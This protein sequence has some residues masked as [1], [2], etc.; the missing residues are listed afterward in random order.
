MQQAPEM[1]GSE[2]GGLLFRCGYTGT[3]LKAGDVLRRLEAEPS[4]VAVVIGVAPTESGTR[5]AARRNVSK[6]P[7]YSFME[8]NPPAGAEGALE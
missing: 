5:V 1:K 3:V 7:I 2:S 6:Q 8:G 4:L